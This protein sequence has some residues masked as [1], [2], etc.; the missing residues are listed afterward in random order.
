MCGRGGAASGEELQYV[1]EREVASE[2]R[3]VAGAGAPVANAS[4]DQATVLRQ[5]KGSLEET[6]VGEL[7]A[8][9]AAGRPLA[10]EMREV[11]RRE[12]RHDLTKQ[13]LFNILVPALFSGEGILSKITAR[14][15][16]LAKFVVN[17]ADQIALVRAW[18]RYYAREE[19]ALGQALP[20]QVAK[21]L[22]EL[23]LVEEDAFL[24]W[25]NPQAT[26]AFKTRA[27]PFLQWLH[28][29]EEEDEDKA[30]T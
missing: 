6:L 9:L 14:K 8:V 25:E 15:P 21:R 18:E 17:Q 19:E 29:A 16:F 24:V 23:D 30:A 27:A 26:S 4:V 11:Q 2:A 5:Y 7:Q 22:Y 12:L 28:E 20:L 1:P 10:D 3:S 13:Q